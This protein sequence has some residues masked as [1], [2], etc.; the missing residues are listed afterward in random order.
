MLPKMGFLNGAGDHVFKY[1]A[2]HECRMDFDVNRSPDYNI[3]EVH[4]LRK[5]HALAFR[6]KCADLGARDEGRAS[7]SR[8][9]AGRLLRD[10][11][12][13]A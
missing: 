3:M 7:I 9:R 4:F 8:L 6:K 12:R 2:P 5:W 10:C 13:P 1:M 11:H